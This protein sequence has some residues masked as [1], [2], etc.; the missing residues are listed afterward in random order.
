MLKRQFGASVNPAP[1][2]L[3][4]LL[5][6]SLTGAASK[7]PASQ[8][9]KQS[10]KFLTIDF[11]KGNLYG[12]VATVPSDFSPLHKHPKTS[13]QIAARGTVTVPPAAHYMF[14]GSGA[15]PENMAVLDL[16]PVECFDILL[17]ED[18]AL[19]DSQLGKL[20]RLQKTC[21]LSL[22]GTDVSDGAFKIAAQM[23]AIEHL[24]I[25][26]SNVNGSGIKF[27]KSLKHLQV[28]R[29]CNNVIKPAY[30][31]DVTAL[32]TL[33]WLDLR[34][35]NLSDND[36]KFLEKLPDLENILLAQNRNLTDDCLVHL[37]GLKKL[38]GIDIKD[39]GISIKK[40][41]RMSFPKLLT[42]QMN[43]EGLTASNEALLKKSFPGLQIHGDSKADKV[44]IQLFNP[45]H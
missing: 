25:A 40:F 24:N 31:E 38:H 41:C 2:A 8:T 18:L 23:P 32:T 34:G 33:K 42:L 1:I 21:F 15:L 10:G 28:L 19:E 45:L 26:H 22:E 16:L 30:L 44:D 4:A 39:T 6:L 9:S 27:L 43:K 12:W 35:L 14:R 11:P 13:P 20:P 37:K 17:L 29:I 5:T 36:L 7:Q 3:F